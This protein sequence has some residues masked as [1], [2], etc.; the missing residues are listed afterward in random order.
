MAQ[1]LIQYLDALVEDYQS[2][3]DTVPEMG[4]DSLDEA[5]EYER[6]EAS[7]GVA[8]TV[9]NH[10]EPL[11]AYLTEQEIYARKCIGDREENDDI[12]E[13]VDD[14]VGNH[15][16]DVIANVT[17][18]LGLPYPEVPD[19]DEDPPDEHLL[20]TVD[21]GGMDP[22]TPNVAILAEHRQSDDGPAIYG[23]YE[24][25]RIARDV[26]IKKYTSGDFDPDGCT[27]EYKEM[28]R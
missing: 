17:R 25:A 12:K 19:E 2:A 23:P 7:N 14:E 9:K 6:I 15:L 22:D 18:I 5:A 4:F 24:T 1:T 20:E 21:L 28:S 8:L 26:A 16:Q 13:M 11:R 10:L 27:I 3:A